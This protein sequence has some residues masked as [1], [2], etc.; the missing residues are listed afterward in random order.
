MSAIQPL[1]NR[2]KNLD[3]QGYDSTKQEE[4]QT[5]I[6]EAEAAISTLGSSKKETAARHELH[7][8]IFSLY[9]RSNQQLTISTPLQAASLLPA[10]RKWYNHLYKGYNPWTFCRD[11]DAKLTEVQTKYPLFAQLLIEN[12]EMQRQFF[13]S[14]MRDNNP[15]E[16]VVKFYHQWLEGP[17]RCCLS[18]R[19]GWGQRKY[20]HI[21]VHEEDGRVGLQ[22]RVNGEWVNILDRQATVNLQNAKTVGELFKLCAGKSSKPG[23][24]DF[25]PEKGF[26][27][28]DTYG[29]NFGGEEI[30]FRSIGWE[31]KVPTEVFTVDEVK[32]LLQR[33]TVVHPNG[34]E[35]LIDGKTPIFAYITNEQGEMNL[36]KTHAFF[37]HFQPCEEGYRF[38][39]NGAYPKTVS[40]LHFMQK[41]EG[42]IQSR[43]DSL[44]TNHRRF[45]FVPYAM[46]KE[47][48]AR[49]M[50]HLGEQ[51]A[52]SKEG[53]FGFEY[54]LKGCAG[55][56]QDL[57]NV[58]YGEI[59]PQPF[60]T[61]LEDV[62]PGGV[63]GALHTI[64]R[65]VPIRWL[66]HLGYAVFKWLLGS[67]RW[68]Y[69]QPPA[70]HHPLHG[71]NKLYHPGVPQQTLRE[72]GMSAKQLRSE[73][74]DGKYD[75]SIF[76]HWEVKKPSL[77]MR[78]IRWIRGTSAKEARLF[79]QA[80]DA[81]ETSK[82]TLDVDR[83][84]QLKLHLQSQVSPKLKSLMEQRWVA[85]TTRHSEVIDAV[86]NSDELIMKFTLWANGYFEK[87]ESSKKEKINQLVQILTTDFRAFADYISKEEN[88]KIR[89]KFL[90]FTLR[91]GNVDRNTISLFVKAPGLTKK[92]K[93]Q[94]LLPRIGSFPATFR[95]E[96]NSPE[97][98]YNY[99]QDGIVEKR[100][101]RLDRP[102]DL[103]R[104]SPDFSLTV[105]EI[106]KTFEDDNKKFGKVIY[107]HRGIVP[108]DVNEGKRPDEEEHDW[109]QDGLKWFLRLPED[110]LI[111][112]EEGKKRF[113][114]DFTGF[115]VNVMA[116]RKRDPQKKYPFDFE[117][118]H[119]YLELVNQNAEGEI[120]IRYLGFFSKGEF[121]HTLMRQ[122]K[123]VGNTV[124]G[125]LVRDTNHSA[126]R[127]RV[128]GRLPHIV[129]EDVFKKFVNEELQYE[130]RK[131]IEGHVPFQVMGA[132]CAYH[133]N[134][135][136]NKLLQIEGKEGEDLFT[137]PLLESTPSGPL[138]YNLAV[139]RRVPSKWLQEKLRKFHL[140]LLSPSRTYR[141]MSLKGTHTWTK[142]TYS[143][144]GQLF[145]HK[146]FEVEK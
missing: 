38:M 11:P 69:E 67:G 130:M 27:D 87:E 2:F 89:E 99:Q 105:E 68:F 59:A 77:W 82:R 101:F 106:L 107:T 30:D 44:C 62:N 78:L 5:W 49:M 14:V 109:T 140:K 115:A 63:L 128:H 46:E 97:I 70:N 16:V 120:E 64:G 144:P 20:E 94:Y 96:N 141:G 81:I 86:C 84:R 104:F 66:R 1:M 93:Y 116:A 54:L 53:K 52:A 127:R 58:A 102:Q 42:V 36:H 121:P 34:K 92:L 50:G 114:T 79:I 61:D 142:G 55:L 139:I 8:R 24:I 132:S 125:V 137:R 57:M 51:I 91:D 100:W 41:S 133:V 73:L 131:G 32:N 95:W 85:Y 129:T 40:F 98:C 72:K 110:E 124:E 23:P 118:T 39:A 80:M 33:E 43:D 9:Y 88:I 6:R 47:E 56:V 134:S 75:E 111:S 19:M 7:S 28:A 31:E 71:L 108:W 117:E 122:L 45:I 21:R 126:Y 48:Y 135:L 29:W 4:Y 113:G 74:F 103:V 10:F 25:H 37:A 13:E 60:L 112:L 18:G 136:Y 138:R 12:E 143:S 90:K 146:D 123:F 76:D 3:T 26:I 145:G 15:V 17:K 22:S 65:R 35:Y 83:V 119:T